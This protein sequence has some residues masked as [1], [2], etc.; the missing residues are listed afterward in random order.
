M[1]L[2]DTDTLSNIVKKTPSSKLLKKLGNLPPDCQFTTSINVAEI[3]YG[4]HRSPHKDRIIQAFREKVFPNLNIL[5]F[6]EESARF[7]GELKAKLEK[8]GISRSEPDLRIA[9]VALQHGLTV[10]TGNTEHFKNIP[11]L[12]IDNW[13]G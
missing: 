4:A 10:I 12:K 9:A 8:K 3:Y 1:Y 7:Y 13:M 5:P 6:D 11:K 2:F